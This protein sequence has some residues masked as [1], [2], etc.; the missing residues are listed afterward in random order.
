MVGGFYENSVSRKVLSSSIPYYQD[1]LTWCVPTAGL[2]SSLSNAFGIFNI[3]IWLIVIII[4]IVSGLLLLQFARIEN[5]HGTENVAWSII[6]SLAFTLSQAGHFFP[7]R[8]PVKIFLALLMFYAFHLNTAYHSFLITVMTKPKYEPQVADAWTAVHNG[9]KFY[10]NEETLAYFVRKGN[11]SVSRTIV[12]RFNVCKDIDTCLAL[13]RTRKKVAIAVSRH[14][15]DNSPAISSNEM[16]CFKRE[17][18]VYTYSVSMLTK[19]QYHLLE[20]INSLLRTISESGLLLRWA[21]Q[22]ENRQVDASD[23]ETTGRHGGGPVVKLKMEHVE[24]GFLLHIIGL[25]IA[26]FAFIGE[27]IFYQLHKRT[28]LARS[29]KKIMNRVDEWFC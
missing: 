27:Y 18:N 24:G 5:K 28:N 17:D 21:Q 12:R 8:A 3:F 15:S 13:I 25:T 14:H 22:S 19:K 20:K 2:A 1:E 4:L 16:Y 11:E 9:Y 29:L 10:G 26:L 23:T 7:Q 6:T